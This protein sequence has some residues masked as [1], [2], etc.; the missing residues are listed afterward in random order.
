MGYVRSVSP[1]WFAPFGPAEGRHPGGITGRLIG[2][3][4]YERSA[5]LLGVSADT[6]E[7]FAE[8]FCAMARAQ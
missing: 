2:M 3:Q 8:Y 5:E 6:P 7:A 1:E 4:F